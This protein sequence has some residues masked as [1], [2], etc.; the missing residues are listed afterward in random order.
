MS[1]LPRVLFVL[2]PDA[3]SRFGGDTVLARNNFEAIKALGV[4]ADLVESD[5]PDARGY[6]IAHIFNIGQ[7]EV[8]ERQFEA[9]E[10]TGAAI[11][12]SPVWLDLEEFF[13]RAQAYHRLFLSAKNFRSVQA[14]IERLRSRDAITFLSWRERTRLRRMRGRQAELL[15]RARVLL[16]NS[17][18]EARDCMVKLRVNTTPF[19][20]VAIPSN[21]EP[22]SYW[23]DVRSG[24]IAVGRVEVR[25]NQ[26]GL[27]FAVRDENFSVDIVGAAY[28]KGIAETCQRLC[29][30]A[31]FT[32]RVERV[33]LLRMLGHAQVHALASW[34]ET[35]GIATLE[36]AAAGAQIVVGDRGAE[37]EYFGDDAEYADPADPES[38]RAAVARAFAR[39]PRQR[40][41]SLDRRIRMNTW[42]QAAQETLRAYRIALG[43]P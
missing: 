12:L 28:D 25:K 5:R 36:A 35:A 27:C 40:G 30:R 20:I 39:G 15:R 37:V 22:A 2:R 7:P 4:S 21:L 13:G 41:D 43:N 14:R 8:A 29:P 16:P 33:E 26:T 24:L 18:F 1:S 3:A 11:A 32:G 38:I 19:A 6:D 9:C 34:C 23:Q 10:K 31:R 17:A 42:A